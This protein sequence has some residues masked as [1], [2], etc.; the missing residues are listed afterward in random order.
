M[1]QDRSKS[2]IIRLT[3]EF[4]AI[5]L[6]V[7]RASITEVLQP[8]QKVGLIQYHRGIIT[9]LNRAGL[10]LDSCECYRTNNE[11]FNRIIGTHKGF[12]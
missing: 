8:L 10:E 1:T 6:G 5:M 4:L 9:V 3:H 11:L 2:D 7:R 12:P